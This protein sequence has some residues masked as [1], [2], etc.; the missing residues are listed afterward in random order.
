MEIGRRGG[1]KV[2]LTRRQLIRTAAG[3]CTVPIVSGSLPAAEGAES[4]SGHLALL[5]DSVFDN[6]RYV[7][8]GATVLDCLQKA[9]PASWQLSLCARDGD[10]TQDVA[11]Q[12]RNLPTTATHIVVSCG[13]NDALAEGGYLQR[14]A[15]TGSELM[16]D[17]AEIQE[18]F[19]RSYRR[20]SDDL[21]ATGKKIVLCTIYDPR[22]EDSNQQK[23]CATALAVFNDVITREAGRRGWP[24]VDLRVLFS[25]RADYANAIEPSQAGGQKLAQTISR[26]IRVGDFS[27][28][29][30]AIYV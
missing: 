6:R 7:L 19:A 27:S 26:V 8:P 25:D 4:D 2:S 18:R 23:A 30:A 11:I 14:V 21:Q 5:G 20:M 28:G 29:T 3:C 13:G 24:L 1:L 16:V 15:P 10:T 17:L 22:F 9:M 12:I